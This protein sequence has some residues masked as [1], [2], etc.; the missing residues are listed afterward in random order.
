M[1]DGFGKNFFPVA[2]AVILSIVPYLTKGQY[3]HIERS[4]YGMKPDAYMIYG[5]KI[6]PGFNQFTQTGSFIGLNTGF[7]GK[8][9]INES[10][11]IAVE[12]LYSMQG[13]GRQTYTRTY[14]DARQSEVVV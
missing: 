3:R 12:A 6:G 9:K 14:N 13:G 11:N 1:R 2:A 7:F 4:N 8:Y 10:F 5:F